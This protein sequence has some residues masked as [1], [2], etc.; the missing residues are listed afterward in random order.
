MAD[1]SDGFAVHC[2]ASGSSANCVLVTTPEG[3]L[4]LDAG[5][6]VRTLGGYL[7][8]RGVDAESLCGICVTHEH[9]DHIAAAVPLSCRWKVPLVATRGT[10]DAVVRADSLRRDPPVKAMG[11]DDEAGVGPFTVRTFGVSHDAAEPC[12]FRVSWRGH[13]L[14]LATDTGVV[15]PGWRDAAVGCELLVVEANHDIERLRLGPYPVSLK[16]RILSADGH[17]DNRSAAQWVLAHTAEH[18][19]TA[20]WW[21]H[22]SEVNNLP[23]L[24]VR[25][26]D[27]AWRSAGLR[28][29]PAATSVAGRDVPSL[30]HRPGKV[31]V[32]PSLF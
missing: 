17:L 4:L 27:Q 30:V 29:S 19:P 20:V 32:Q 1:H 10:L 23:S 14:A 28:S 15:T 25:E 8:E 22:L 18:G 7:K 21:A 13:A 6:G 5:I 24:V 3:S 12:G 9:G 16:R 31:A 2:L 26:W 11:R